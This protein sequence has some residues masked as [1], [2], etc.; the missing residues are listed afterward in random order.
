VGGSTAAARA[1]PARP[2]AVFRTSVPAVYAVCDRPKPGPYTY[3]WP[4]K[5]FDRQHPVRGNFGDPRTVTT[6]TF[7][8]DKPGSIGSFGFHNGID[9]AADTGT[10]VYPVVSGVVVKSRYD[11]EVIVATALDRSFQYFHIAP[12]VRPGQRVSAYRTILG[13]VKPVWHHVHLTEIDGFRV[14]NPL[15]PGHLEPYQDH[16]V[17]A[18]SQL[19][20]NDGHGTVLDPSLLHGRVEITAEADDLPPLPVPGFWFGFPVTPALVAWR[21]T[22]QGHVPVLSETIAADFRRS[23]PPNRDFWQVYAAGTYQNFPVFDHDYFFQTPG[24]Y[25]FRLTKEPLDTHKLPNGRYGVTVDVADVC[26]NFA[27]LT[28]H[29]TIDNPRFRGE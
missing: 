4:I 23:E 12:A 5:P 9:I 6:A 10:A 28:D 1:G 19:S 29:V 24:H 18:V 17:P 27:S 2:P 22:R 3:H 7:G 16:T 13:T 14:H 25:W 26:G 21:M 11:D 20:F 8:E 15:D